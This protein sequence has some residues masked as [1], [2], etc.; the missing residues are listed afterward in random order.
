L[1]RNWLKEPRRYSLIDPIFP[2]TLAAPAEVQPLAWPGH[3]D[4]RYAQLF[5]DAGFGQGTV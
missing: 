1:G 5:L 4:I 2:P 3:G